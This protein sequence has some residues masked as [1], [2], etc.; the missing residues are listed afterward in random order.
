MNILTNNNFLFV[1]LI[2]EINFGTPVSLH[3][4][5]INYTLIYMFLFMNILYHQLI[6]LLCILLH[7]YHTKYFENYE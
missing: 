6:F 7:P 5:Y 4:F 2:H 3:Y 1:F